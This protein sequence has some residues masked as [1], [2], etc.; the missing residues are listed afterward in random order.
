LKSVVFDESLEAA[1]GRIPAWERLLGV[2]ELSA[3]FSSLQHSYPGLANVQRLGLSDEGQEIDLVS[4]GCGKRSALVVGGPHPNEPIGCLTVLSLQQLLLSDETLRDLLDTTWHFIT[5]IDPDGLRR[6]STWLGK[7]LTLE[8]YF[9]GFFR[10]HF[11]AQ[12]EYTFPYVWDGRSFNAATPENQAW[13]RALNLTRPNLQV[14]LHNSD[15]GGVFHLCSSAKPTLYDPLQRLVHKLG[16]TVSSIGEPLSELASLAEGVFL[17][18]DISRLVAGAA[19]DDGQSWVAGDTSAGFAKRYDTF[20]ITTEVPFWDDSRLEDRNISGATLST[21]IGEHLKLVEAGQE[22]LGSSLDVL[23]QTFTEKTRPYI[24][25][26]QEAQKRNTAQIPRMRALLIEG[27]LSSSPLTVGDALYYRSTLLLAGLRPVAMLRILASRT[28][29]QSGDARAR[30]VSET[31]SLLIRETLQQ[32][33]SISTMRPVPLKASCGIQVGAALIAA[34][35][36][37]DS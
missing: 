10:P 1:L 19:A 23:A 12:P 18:P 22:Q 33:R 29:D 25:A 17:F 28:Y 16:L 27:R 26:L 37:A 4:I 32:L 35:V 6:N 24:E 9:Q 30:E 11:E 3:Q 15:F 14:S 7:E 31:A 34:K 13:Q 20:S 21:V 5:A 2:E 36:L 8:N